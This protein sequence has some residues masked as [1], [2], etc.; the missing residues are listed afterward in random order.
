MLQIT[1]ASTNVRE[2]PYTDKKG[3]PAKLMIQQAYAHTFDE[4][5]DKRPF[6]DRF[7]IVLP[8]GVETPYPVGEYTLHPSALS[9]DNNGRLSCSPLLTPVQQPKPRG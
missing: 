5:G 6:P 7:D 2:I 3:Q 8:R 4:M 1:V 9:V